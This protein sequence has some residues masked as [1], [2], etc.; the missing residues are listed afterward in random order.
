MNG[1]L[2]RIWSR[3]LSPRSIRSFLVEPL[4][5]NS[6]YILMANVLSAGFGLLFWIVAARNYAPE[7]V[8]LATALISIAGVILLVSRLGVDQSMTRYLPGGDR[9]SIYSTAVI[10]TTTLSLLFGVGYL[11]TAWFWSSD[12]QIGWGVGFAMI[13]LILA[14]SVSLTSNMALVSIR[15]AKTSL[16]QTVVMGSRIIFLL[17]FTALGAIGIVGAFA[18]SFVLSVVYGQIVL[19]KMGI[20][21]RG[22][23]WQF[24]RNSMRFSSANWVGGLLDNLPTYLLPILVYNHLGAAQT[25]EYY[26]AFSFASIVFMFPRSFALQMYV[27][28]CHGVPLKN[29]VVKS[30]WLS[31]AMVLP[32][33][34]LLYLLSPW[35]LGLLGGEY[36][37]N[38]LTLLRL[39]A[40]SCILWI[41][42]R[43][44]YQVKM[45]QKDMKGMVLISVTYCVLI[46][47]LSYAFM[48]LY[49]LNGIGYAWILASGIVSV[50]ILLTV[51]RKPKGPPAAT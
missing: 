18:L 40:F 8:G 22:V 51:V 16:V 38:G 12:L 29:V 21:I 9:S 10:V 47:G 11:L 37:E 30:A 35:L 15:K 28:G 46:V 39:L 6:V 49:G 7:Y 26:M 43:I 42:Y 19:S 33:V 13:L 31:F 48:L 4:F 23:D 17:I 3:Y 44:F 50:I 41:P 45:V 24:I 34:A 36:A 5:A 32:V 1:V 14:W 27:E 25:A 2:D 20:S